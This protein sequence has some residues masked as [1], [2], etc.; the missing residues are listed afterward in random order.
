MIGLFLGIF[1]LLMCIIMFMFGSGGL[2]GFLG[3]GF[4]FALALWLIFQE[5]KKKVNDKKTS[6]QGEKC[7]ARILDCVKTGNFILNK[8][9]YKVITAVYVPSL[10]KKLILEEIVGFNNF[11]Q[12][13]KDSFFSVLYHNNDI[14]IK[15]R[16]S[17]TEIPNEILKVLK[18]EVVLNEYNEYKKENQEIQQVAMEEKI[19][20]ATSIMEKVQL[21]YKRIILGIIMIILL[22]N[23]LFDTVIIKQTIIARDYVETIATYVDKKVS[24]ENSIFDDYIYIRLKIKKEQSKKLL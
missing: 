4:V 16:L 17:E 14:N 5:L 12:Y 23:I 13:P 20:K 9:E 11:E 2:G 8:E 18:D 10:Q 21:I 1:L 6:V 15:E 22:I 24:D 19:Q 3:V 7:C